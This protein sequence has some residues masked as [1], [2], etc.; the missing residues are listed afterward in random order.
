MMAA[1]ATRTT[2]RATAARTGNAVA[3]AEAVRHCLLQPAV[4]VV[5]V[6]AQ[7]V[8][9]QVDGAPARLGHAAPLQRAKGQDQRV[10]YRRPGGEGAEL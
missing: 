7:R 6:Q 9:E 8:R 5:P 4:A 10:A 1:A 3:T 2:A